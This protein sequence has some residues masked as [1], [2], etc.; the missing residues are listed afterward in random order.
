MDF[1]SVRDELCGQLEQQEY[2]FSGM[3]VADMRRALVF[4]LCLAVNASRLRDEAAIARELSEP[5][6]A[7]CT[8]TVYDNDELGEIANALL[9]I[10]TAAPHKVGNVTA[11]ESKTA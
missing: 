1:G 8:P 3:A 2:A 11:G 6:P 5:W 9:W 4:G 7:G 10:E